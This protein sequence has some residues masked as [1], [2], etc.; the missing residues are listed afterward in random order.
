MMCPV[1]FAFKLKEYSHFNAYNT[2]KICKTHYEKLTIE[3]FFYFTDENKI[4]SQVFKPQTS[5]K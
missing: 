4:H 3:I 2:C 1:L 5:R